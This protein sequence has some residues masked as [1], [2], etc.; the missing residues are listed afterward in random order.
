[1][2]EQP[3]TCR[4][5][6][7][8]IGAVSWT[9]FTAI[10]TFVITANFLPITKCGTIDGNTLNFPKDIPDWTQVDRFEIKEKGLIISRPTGGKQCYLIP[11]RPAG[12]DTDQPRP[13]IVQ[14]Q[15]LNDDMLEVIAGEDG[16]SFC[17][18]Y[19]TYLTSEMKPDET[20]RK[21]EDAPP[22]APTS[23]TAEGGIFGS[24]QNQGKQ[25]RDLT[26]DQREPRCTEV[27]LDCTDHVG[28]VQ[29][30]YTW[31]NGVLWM[32]RKCTDSKQFNVHMTKPPGRIL[33]IAQQ[34][35]IICLQRR[36]Q[37]LSC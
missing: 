5:A 1:M 13:L 27:L 35:W 14:T 33:K 32:D 3:T 15:P 17:N 21:R 34:E 11:I 12:Q 28:Q 2:K 31:V 29:S 8:I 26:I 7:I 16:A 22:S 30:C 6:T 19:V 18:G 4:N 36:N 20:R 37:G 23:G 25:A 10:I 24:A 9:I